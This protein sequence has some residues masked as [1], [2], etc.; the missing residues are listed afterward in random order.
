MALRT[1][2]GLANSEGAPKEAYLSP[3]LDYLLNNGNSLEMLSDILEAGD[4]PEKLRYDP[5][6]T[7]ELA[8]QG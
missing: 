8:P 2:Y 3:V 5:M 7:E 4:D 1:L 6:G